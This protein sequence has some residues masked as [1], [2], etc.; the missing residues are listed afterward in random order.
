M[1]GSYST[2]VRFSVYILSIGPTTVPPL[3][4]EQC[5]EIASEAAA[6]TSPILSRIDYHPDSGRR[7]SGE[8][9]PEPR[10]STLSW[11]T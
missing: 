4:D 7:R 1:E 5:S 2:E 6:E 8:W 9:R 11:R 3:P 10:R